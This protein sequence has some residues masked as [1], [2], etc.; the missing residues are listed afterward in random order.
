MFESGS[1]PIQ[2]N[3]G[4]AV[5]ASIQSQ[6][7]KILSSAVFRKSER[8]NRLL[9]F[10]VESSI[11]GAK[12]PLK[13][14]VIAT[15]VF[16]KRDSFDPQSDPIVRVQAK[17]LR[18]KLLAYYRA[19]GSSDPIEILLPVQSYTPL[20]R[21]RSQGKPEPHVSVIVVPFVSVGDDPET[22]RFC[23]GVTEEVIH[24]LT[25][26]DS[27]RVV[28]ADASAKYL[29]RSSNTPES[30][31]ESN[32][33]LVLKGT[34]RVSGDRV[35]VATQ[36]IQVTDGSYQWSEIYDRGSQDLLRVQ[37]DISRAIVADLQINHLI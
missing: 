1:K 31:E 14:Y 36:L 29:R 34:A 28:A 33:E 18:A 25:H 21:T 2:E 11:T 16:D 37:E 32:A 30:R 10:L 19:E 23:I 9:R 3:R 27:V 8:L 35:R 12:G 7:N 15:E 20:I 17:R 24:K 5:P 13:E 6:L 26:C 4:E 22:R